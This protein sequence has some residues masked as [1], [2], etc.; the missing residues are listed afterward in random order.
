VEQFWN[1]MIDPRSV[2]KMLYTLRMIDDFIPR[3]EDN[4]VRT[5]TH[6]HTYSYTYSTSSFTFLFF[7]LHFWLPLVNSY[8][9]A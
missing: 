4:E 9:S 8:E 2:F 3:P 6:T 1:E 5:Y 7:G